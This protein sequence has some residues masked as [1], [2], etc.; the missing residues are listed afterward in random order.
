MMLSAALTAEAGHV[1]AQNKERVNGSSRGEEIVRYRTVSVDGM[2]IFY[3]EA[4]DRNKPTILFLHGFPSSS[5]MYRD[6]M[7]DLAGRYHVIAPD[8]PG[9]GYSSSP[10]PAAYTYTFDA[11]ALV[12]E[13]FMDAVQLKRVVLYMQDYGGPVGFR[14]ATRRPESIKGFIIQNANAYNEGLGPALEPLAAYMNDPGPATERNARSILTPEVT[15]WQ[16]TDGAEDVTRISPDSYTTDQHFLDRPGN[17]EIQLA[18]FRNYATNLGLYDQW[19]AFLRERQPS[20]L[21]IWG[22]ND[23]LFIAPGAEAFRK[24]L[25]QVEIHLLNGG[26]FLLEEH[27]AEAA[28]LIDGWM[29]KLK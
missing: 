9:F 19:H 7:R 20:T 18:L 2:E 24:D 28:Q 4:G 22:K 29:S 14:L 16:Y 13:H 26:H 1:D 3:R 17:D 6:I 5:H 27:H 21:I 8:L 11:L 15:K 10:S 25:K 23:K 12:M